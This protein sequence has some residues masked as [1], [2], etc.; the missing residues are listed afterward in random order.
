MRLLILT[1]KVDMNDDLLGFFH[2]WLREFALAFTEV[3]VI[4]LGE[5][6]YKLPGNLKVFSLGK[7][8]GGRGIIKKISYAYN[9]YKYIFSERKNYDAVFVHMNQ[10]YVLM[11]GL[12]WKIWK[13]K[14]G[15]WYVHKKVSRKLKLAE[16]LSDYIFTASAES[17]NLAS[18]KVFVTGHG[19]NTERF[20]TV[21]AEK[22]PTGVFKIIYVGRI[23]PI[24]NQ[25]LLIE[26][27]NYLVN[28]KE[29]KGLRVLF[30]GSPVYLEDSAYFNQ[31]KEMVRRDKL[32]GCVDFIGSIPYREMPKY[33][34]NADLAANL[35]PTGGMDKAV[36]EA[37]ASGVTAVA[38][39]KTFFPVFGRYADLLVLNSLSKGEL[40]EKI[41]LIKRMAP[42]EQIV[43]AE[44]LKNTV[45]GKFS[46]KN[47]IMKIAKHYEGNRKI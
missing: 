16:K 20:S 45:A 42:G 28:E 21:R 2:D 15:L 24:K 19:I 44:F 46:L 17:F 41:L 35:C 47:L 3:T 31:L 14:I 34:A 7:E 10:E 29:E 6:K 27:V 25:K 23:S 33:L 22:K 5:G 43:L 37:M 18:N 8:K 32:E 39:N 40:A 13:K 1:Q 30:I 26:A 4:C 38:L 36:L 11:G 12:L 9:F